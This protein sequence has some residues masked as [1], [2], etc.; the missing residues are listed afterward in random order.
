ML[1]QVSKSY[2]PGRYDSEYEEKGN[3][4]PFAYVRWTENRNIEAV[5]R[6]MELGNLN[7]KPL[8]SDRFEF[9][10]IISAYEKLR[11]KTEKLGILIKYKN[12]KD[13]QHIISLPKKNSE[14][15]NETLNSNIG[16]IGCELFLT[17]NN[18]FINKIQIRYFS[19][20]V[21]NKIFFFWKKFNFEKISTDIDS[22]IK[23]QN[24]SDFY[25]Y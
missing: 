10:N 25:R 23:N 9:K 16:V 7:V 6:A 22:I 4:Y 17:S 1:F 19:V 12:E 15:F 14:K 3:D 21:P 13:I 20:S 5:L 2:G 18:S 11:D 8:I 24:I